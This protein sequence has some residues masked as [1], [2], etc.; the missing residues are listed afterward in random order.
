MVFWMATHLNGFI[1]VPYTHKT[2]KSM[3]GTSMARLRTAAFSALLQ[4]PTQWHDCW[5]QNDPEAK[6]SQYNF[7][8][9]ELRQ[10]QDL[11]DSNLSH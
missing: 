11:H 6:H 8:Q 4:Q 9:R 7:R 5:S 2:H 10:L 1:N 3:G